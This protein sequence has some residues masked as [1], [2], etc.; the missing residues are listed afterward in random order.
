MQLFAAVVCRQLGNVQQA[1]ADIDKAIELEPG[2]VDAYWQ[3]HLVN[4]LLNRIQLAVDDLNTLLQLKKS[5]VAALKS[6]LVCG[7]LVERATCFR[8]QCDAIL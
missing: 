2:L 8:N 1:M 3:R 5:H 7:S 4:V 6:R